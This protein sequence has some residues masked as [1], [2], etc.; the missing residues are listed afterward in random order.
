M[1]QSDNFV[2]VTVK[3]SGKGIAA[4][5]IENICERFIRFSK[6]N[7]G[8]E[9]GLPIA[10][11]FVEDHSGQIIIESFQ[12]KS[13]LFSITLSTKKIKSIFYKPMMKYH[14]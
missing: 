4:N 2:V 11:A 14:Y 5:E 7:Q 6:H 12:N 9:Q 10:K 3:D 1:E 13:S 8:L